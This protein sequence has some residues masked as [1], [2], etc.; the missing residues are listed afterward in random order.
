MML[1]PHDCGDSTIRLRLRSIQLTPNN[2]GLNPRVPRSSTHWYS[3][4]PTFRIA[5][6]TAIA[7]HNQYAVLIVEVGNAMKN[8]PD[9][10]SVDLSKTALVRDSRKPTQNTR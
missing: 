6:G 9:V 2:D 7:D 10:I 8:K 1:E 3:F 5:F 4:H